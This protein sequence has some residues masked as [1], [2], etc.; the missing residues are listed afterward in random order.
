DGRRIPRLRAASCGAAGPARPQRAGR[1]RAAP[2]L[3]RRRAFRDPR[4]A[5][6]RA[7]A[8][9]GRSHAA[10]PADPQPGQ[11]C[12][13][14]DRAG[15][16]SRDRGPD[17]VAAAVRWRV[18]GPRAGPRQWRR[19]RAVGAGARV[20]ALRDE[21]AARH[22][23]GPGDRQEDRRRARCAHR[24]EQL[25][26]PLGQDGRGP[27]F[28]P[29]YQIGKKRGKS[30]PDRNRHLD[31]TQERMAE[32]LVVDD[33]IGIRELLSEILGDEGHTVLLAE[34]AQ[35]A[36]AVREANR[37]DLVLLDIWM[38]DTDG[39]TLLKEWASGG[40]LT[41]PVIMMS[42]H[43][44][45]DTAVESTR[46]GT[47]DFLEKPITLQKLLKAVETGLLRGRPGADHSPAAPP[48]A[49]S[50]RAVGGGFQASAPVGTIPAIGAA[51]PQPLGG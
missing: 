35:Q 23:A 45:I 8:R 1:R 16:A 34:S 4:A 12:G 31:F 21:Q 40:K 24:R 36:R 11:E 42:G 13:R 15:R 7:A 9:D 32:I 27:D 38:P 17:R 18:R 3:G 19:L 30:S 25:V 10:A 49:A 44:T 28:G 22:R 14:G 47:L 26:R 6:Q 29:I 43:A 5:R 50:M 48:S 37:L 39:V 20:R 51:R 33:E 46:I 41:M 2:V